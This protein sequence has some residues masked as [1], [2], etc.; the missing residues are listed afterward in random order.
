MDARKLGQ[1][2]DVSLGQGNATGVAARGTQGVSK[3][4]G[5]LG[6]FFLAR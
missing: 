6:G 2:V 1:W 5:D 3:G 4:G